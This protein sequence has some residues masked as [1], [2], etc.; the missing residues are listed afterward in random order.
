[1]NYSRKMDKGN[2]IDDIVEYYAAMKRNKL[3]THFTRM[4]LI[5]IM[6]SK[7]G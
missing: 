4:T 5:A 7:R 1:M 6:L 2:R 3:L